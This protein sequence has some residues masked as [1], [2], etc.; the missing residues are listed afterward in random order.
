MLYEKRKSRLV[1]KISNLKNLFDGETTLSAI[2]AN[3]KNSIIA[4][5][6]QIL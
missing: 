5:I 1:V 6:R 4:M 3:S 2:Q